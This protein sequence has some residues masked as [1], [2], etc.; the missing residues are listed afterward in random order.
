MVKA[1][2]GWTGEP[3]DSLMPC[4]SGTKNCQLLFPEVELNAP[5]AVSE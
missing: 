1:K 4:T 5:M 2:T 3:L